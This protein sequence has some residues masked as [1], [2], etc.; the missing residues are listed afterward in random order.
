MKVP[1]TAKSIRD[2]DCL[3]VAPLGDRTF[4]INSKIEVMTYFNS[5]ISYD[6]YW[7]NFF[8]ILSLLYVIYTIIGKYYFKFCKFVIKTKIVFEKFSSIN[9]AT[10]PRDIINIQNISMS[11]YFNLLYAIIYWLWYNLNQMIIIISSFL[12]IY[13]KYFIIWYFNI[14]ISLIK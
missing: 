5:T 2:C 3:I 10:V 12:Y 6:I 13:I 7:I 1:Y 9:H 4:N 8:L 11:R 14:F